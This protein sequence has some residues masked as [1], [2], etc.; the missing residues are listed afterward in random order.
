[1]AAVGKNQPINGGHLQLQ[2]MRIHDIVLA[3]QNACNPH[4]CRGWGVN[5]DDQNSDMDIQWKLFS[6]SFRKQRHDK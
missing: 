5:P 4:E 3:K 6:E 2:P 1:M